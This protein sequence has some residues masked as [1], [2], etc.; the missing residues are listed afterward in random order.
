MLLELS[1]ASKPLHHDCLHIL[2]TLNHCQRPN[3]LYS[4]L[5]IEEFIVTT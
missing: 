4:A 2:F 5:A 3:Y 1:D